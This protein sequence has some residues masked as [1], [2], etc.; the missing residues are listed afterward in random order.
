M[1]QSQLNS[2][3]WS[4]KCNRHFCVSSKWQLVVNQRP[5]RKPLLIRTILTVQTFWADRRGEIAAETSHR[6]IM[7]SLGMS[8][9]KLSLQPD[10]GQ[11]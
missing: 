11:T 1:C 5:K 2:L 3:L 8:Q 10:L 9:F 7:P 4:N 6:R